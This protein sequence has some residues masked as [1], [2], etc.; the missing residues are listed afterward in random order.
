MKYLNVSTK[1]VGGGVWALRPSLVTIIDAMFAN[2]SIATTT[3]PWPTDRCLDG[4]RVTMNGGSTDQWAGITERRTDSFPNAALLHCLP[5]SGGQRQRDPKVGMDCTKSTPL[6]LPPPPH[7]PIPTTNV[8]RS[9]SSLQM[10]V[11]LDNPTPATERERTMAA[12][13]EPWQ[14]AVWD[15]HPH[16]RLK[17]HQEARRGA[18][19]LPTP[20]LRRPVN[21]ARTGSGA[22]GSG[23]GVK[24]GRDR[25][26]LKTGP[27]DRQH[28][29]SGA[30]WLSDTSLVCPTGWGGGTWRA[31]LLFFL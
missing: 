16:W 8:Y 22:T 1:W 25:T 3:V 24:A 27:R 7:C 23:Q 19:A 11:C 15:R 4:R 10:S 6:L 21:S 28:G 29:D 31:P 26:A 13:R 2:H 5:T 20:A 9:D 18:G 14:D 17:P 30:C 12:L